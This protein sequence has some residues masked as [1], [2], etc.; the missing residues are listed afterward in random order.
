MTRIVSNKQNCFN[1]INPTKDDEVYV[2]IDVHKKSYAVAVWLNN[3][4][5]VDFVTPADNQTVLSMLNKLRI[6]LKQVV[7]EA[8]PTG[9]SLARLLHQAALPI[10]VVAPSKTPRQSATDS[11]IDRLVYQL[12]DL[13]EEEIKIIEESK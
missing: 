2:G 13:T 9:Y 8:S 3:A 11:R 10:R 7:Y 6:A 1:K 4:P 5:A 12:Y